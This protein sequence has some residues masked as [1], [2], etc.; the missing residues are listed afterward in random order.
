MNL[1]IARKLLNENLLTENQNKAI[2]HIEENK[3]FSLH[4]ELRVLLY[5]GVMLLSTG[6]G[7]FIYENIDTIGHITIIALIGMICAACF[8]YCFNKRQNYSNEEVKS[9]TPFFD[10]ALLLGCLLFI[11]LESYLQFQYNIFGVRYGL[12]TIIPALLFFYFAYLFDNR[13]ILSFAVTGLAAWLGISITPLEMFNSGFFYN[14]TQLIY[15]GILLGSFLTGSAAF[16]SFKKIKKHFEFTYFN[17][18]ANLLFISILGGLF[19]LDLKIIYVLF[20]AACCYAAFFYAKKEQ[21][22]YMYLLCVVYGYIGITYLWFNIFGETFAI[23]SIL[24]YMIGSA[25]GAI[26]LLGKYKQILGI[27]K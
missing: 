23:G 25:A 6:L 5:I 19:F 27:K 4:W 21:S 2:K 17:F 24:F 20:L 18:A 22:L 15:T 14:N 16:L 12:A 7:I 13:A 10:Y 3:L 26:F 8:Y 11:T 1:S 9:A